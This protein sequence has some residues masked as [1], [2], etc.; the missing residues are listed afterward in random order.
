MSA[1]VLAVSGF[2][3][4]RSSLGADL[5]L[6]TEVLAVALL[7]IGV[8]YAVRHE[9]G[10]HRGFQTVGVIVSIIPAVLWMIPSIWKNTL[11]DFPGNLDD[12]GQ[13]LTVAHSAVAVVAVILGLLLVIRGNQRMA[14]GADMSGY[15]TAM[16]VAYVLY[17]AAAVLGIAVYVRIYG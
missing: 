2:I 4:S 8:F 3:T 6:I 14:A 10:R 5:S 9:Y 13:V 16:R 15:K 1:V 7:T 17:V 12:A 11:P